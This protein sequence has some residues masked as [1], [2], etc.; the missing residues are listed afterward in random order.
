MKKTLFILIFA[1]LYSCSTIEEKQLIG[2][3]Y[4]ENDEYGFVEFIFYKDSL[5][6]YDK[7]GLSK[8]VWKADKSKIYLTDID[9]F[10][11]LK[12]LT[13]LYEIDK[14][15]KLLNLKVIRDSLIQLPE[16]TKAKSHYDFFQ[17]NL[18][19]SINLPLTNSELKYIGF[20]DR[21]SF[22]VYAGYRNDDLIVKTDLSSD[23]RNLEDE[24]NNFKE[25]SR[26]ELKPHLKFHL[27][28]DKEI[29][30]N[31]ID[32]IKSLMRKTAIKKIFRVYK[33]KPSD[34]KNTLNWFGQVE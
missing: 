29:S 20:P 19:L 16:L 9:G 24:V 13:Y 3:W 5:V 10:T 11:E 23:L 31:Q 17:K 18:D 21:L 12:Q 25:N 33:T 27:I 6:V 15:K 28:A 4:L 7:L 1:L 8:S 14:S 2:N 30:K 22:N 26:E 34:Y 32:S